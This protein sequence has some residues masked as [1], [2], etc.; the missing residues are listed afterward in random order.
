[1]DDSAIRIK[2]QGCGGHTIV[3]VAPG[4]TRAVAC[5]E[6]GAHLVE[7]ESLRGFI[8]V[9]SHPRMP[10]LLKIG[11]TTR[12]VEERV[13][14]LNTTTAVPGPFV[15]EAVFPS[16]KPE[17]HE[18]AVHETLAEARVESK[19]FF[20]ADLAGAVRKVIATLESPR[21]QR[22]KAVRV[23]IALRH[24]LLLS[25]HSRSLTSCESVG[26]AR[27]DVPTR[28]ARP[29]ACSTVYEDSGMRPFGPPERR[30]GP[31]DLPSGSAGATSPDMSGR[32]PH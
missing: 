8:Y 18:S 2:C 23:V 19:E 10:N 3:I 26:F 17:Q 7:F 9:L 11:F 21:H 30:L 31:A 1:M 13:A 32:R 25:A 16:S 20:K 5:S 14:E 15:I 12:Q 28:I 6:C 27:T 29:N 22:E 4:T 24:S